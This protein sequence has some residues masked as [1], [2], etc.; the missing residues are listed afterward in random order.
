M[1]NTN[2]ENQILLYIVKDTWHAKFIGP[3]EESIVRVFGTNTLPLPF[4]ARASAD[5]VRADVEQR[6]PDCF[7]SVA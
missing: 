6:N 2:M 1:E 7:V 5:T 4:T 3:H